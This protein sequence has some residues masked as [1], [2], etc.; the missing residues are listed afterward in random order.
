MDQPRLDGKRILFVAPPFFGYHL[1]IIAEIESRGAHVDWLPDRPL[2]NA[3]GKALTRL[4][5]KLVLPFADRL[6]SKLLAAFAASWYDYILVINGQT[7]S[8]RFVCHLRNSFPG[9]ALILYMW[10]SVANRSRASSMFDLFDNVYTFDPID[11]SRY[12]LVLRPLFFVSAFTV[13]DDPVSAVYDI[14][15]IGTAHTDR[16]AVIDSL[17]KQLPDSIRAY[18][19]LYLQAHWVFCVYRLFKPGMRKAKISEFRFVPLDKSVINQIFLSSR[20]ILDVSHPRQHGLTIRT[21]EALGS[22]KKLITTN[23]SVRDYDFYDESTILILDRH[24]PEF[25]SSFLGTPCAPVSQHFLSR[26]SLSGWLNEVL[27]LCH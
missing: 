4:A 9:A 5:P 8:R 20:A 22:G 13:P 25:N 19:Y 24:S 7:L 1:D 27:S 11:A 23:P 2:N 16:Y 15:F 17:K 12:N 10:D 21:L 14:S 18:W 6:Y 3:I 26:Y